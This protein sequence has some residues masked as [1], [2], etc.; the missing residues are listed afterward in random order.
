MVK[1]L[2]VTSLKATLLLFCWPLLGKVKKKTTIPEA[3][4]TQEESEYNKAFSNERHIER[5]VQASTEAV[6]KMREE[7][8][9]EEEACKVAAVWV[10]AKKDVQLCL[11]DSRAV[12]SAVRGAGAAA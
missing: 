12:R 5:R 2:K 7:L 9:A 4:L 10:Q 11:E 8:K 3:E 1:A 6:D